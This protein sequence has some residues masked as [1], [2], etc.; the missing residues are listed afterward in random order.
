VTILKG[1]EH[2]PP[3]LLLQLLALLKRIHENHYKIPEIESKYKRVLAGYKGEISL[4]YYLS[5][6]PQKDFIIL[7]DIRLKMG[8]HYFQ[9]D[10]LILHSCYI[11]VLEVKNISGEIYIDSKYSQMIR[12]KDG[13]TDVFPDPILQANKQAGELKKW[14][15]ENKLPPIPIEFL[16]VF[17]NSKTL[18]KNTSNDQDV[19]R[20]LIRNT[21]LTG[22]IVHYCRKY[23]DEV[24]S[25]K[26]LIKLSKKIIKHH[27]PHN[28]DILSLFDLTEE[29]IQ[30]GVYCS[31]CKKFSVERVS[32]SWRCKLCKHSD[33]Y[34]HID[35]LTDY[36]LLY[37][38]SISN[39]EMRKFL[40]INSINTASKLL[41]KM[42]FTSTGST[43][44]RKYEI[45]IL[46]S[47]I[48]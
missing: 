19:Y 37:K 48:F 22:R 5:L 42:K 24:F 29:D 4:D 27:Q 17:T 14:L 39:G 11:L 30:T 43:K 38:A 8:S 10:T 16:V 23:S 32:G 9:I 3:K 21:K 41:K 13:Q 44:N 47:K 46:P 45:P 36:A 40:N 15:E 7:H 26:V 20:R 34:A 12:T 28:Q 33:K 31:V 6:L 25:K 18:I 35:A 1:K 2:L